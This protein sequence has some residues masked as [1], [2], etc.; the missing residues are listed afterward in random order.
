MNLGPEVMPKAPREVDSESI[1]PSLIRHYTAIYHKLQ[2]A[3]KA[4]KTPHY[5]KGHLPGVKKDSLVLGWS[6]CPLLEGL[7]GGEW[8]VKGLCNHFNRNSQRNKADAGQVL[9]IHM[10]TIHTVLLNGIG[11]TEI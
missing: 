5:D 4:T 7:F 9:Y 10:Y 11:D 8:R 1:Y 6:L 2:G 3:G